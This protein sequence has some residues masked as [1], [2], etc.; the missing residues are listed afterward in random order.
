MLRIHSQEAVFPAN[1]NNTSA[2]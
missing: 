2:R 1:R